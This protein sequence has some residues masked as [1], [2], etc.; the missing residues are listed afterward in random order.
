M[1]YFPTFVQHHQNMDRLGRSHP[2]LSIPPSIFSVLGLAL[3]TLLILLNFP[4]AFW[5]APGSLVLV[6]LRFPS[7]MAHPWFHRLGG[8][9]TV[10]VLTGSL[11]FLSI[12]TSA[13]PALA[14]LFEQAESEVQNT[15]GTY[16]DGSVITFLFSLI[17]VVIWIA[18]VGFVFFAVYQ[19]Q[20]GEQWQPLAQNAFIVIAAI[21]VVEA[22]GSLFFG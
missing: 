21:V 20:R 17:R 11:V 13:D 12:V 22:L 19:A 2:L 15:F 1:R 7:V 10:G 4:G 8:F 3:V 14:Q 9:K 6:F 16:I 5:L 18:A